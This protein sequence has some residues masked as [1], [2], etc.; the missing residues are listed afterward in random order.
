MTITEKRA[1]L[2]NLQAKLTGI[3][4]KAQKEKRDLTKEEQTEFDTILNE[5]ESLRTE[6]VADEDRAKKL[7]N[8]QD[9]LN[10]PVGTPRSQ[11]VGEPDESKKTDEP[12]FRSLGDWLL[13]P[14]YKEYRAMS[15]GN[16]G[17]GGLLVPEKFKQQ[18]LSLTGEGNI[19]RPRATI[20]DAGDPPDAKVTIPMFGQGGTNGINGG[21]SMQWI[22]EGGTKA[23][24]TPA[25]TEV[26]LEPKEIGGSTIIT[27]KL[28]RNYAPLSSWLKMQYN[29]LVNAKEDYQFLR[30]NGVGKPRGVLG[31]PCEK[32]V[33][34]AAASAIDL[35]DVVNMLKVLMASSW[36]KAVWIAN[37]SCLSEIITLADANG[38]SIFIQGNITKG[39]PSTLFGIPIIF[40]GKLPT[41][42][43]KGDL[44]L[45]DFSYYLIQ[46]GSGPYFAS[47]EHVYFTTNKTVVKMFKMVDGKMWVQSTLLLEDGSTTVSPVVTLV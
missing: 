26:E 33:L 32:T 29:L 27:D 20:L 23:D 4:N 44:M 12:E 7:G 28:L 5:S 25:F 3:N 15:M 9:Y 39:V 38:N 45:V 1:E 47:S 2:V 17:S 14:E 41:L 37:Q 13:S 36:G 19:V 30:G 34:R 11:G 6:I 22:D 18:I 8:L 43:T 40:N 35:A 31:C 42:G 16:A 21:M 46:D 24:T 10:K